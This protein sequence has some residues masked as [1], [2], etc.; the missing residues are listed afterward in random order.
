[1]KAKRLIVFII[2]L[3]DN[4]VVVSQSIDLRMVDDFTPF[5]LSLLYDLRLSLKVSKVGLSV[6]KV[7]NHKW[8]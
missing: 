4:R 1:M 8:G 5:S 2:S 3:A 6:Q 7:I